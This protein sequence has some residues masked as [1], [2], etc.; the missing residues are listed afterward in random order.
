V[1]VSYNLYFSHSISS[2]FYSCFFF[3]GFGLRLLISGL[4]DRLAG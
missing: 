2:F 3:F 1:N 4:R